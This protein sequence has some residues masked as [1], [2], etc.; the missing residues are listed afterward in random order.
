M[1][2]K[3]KLMPDY[4]CWPLWNIEEPDNINPAELPLSAKT[5]EGLLKWAQTFDE[6]LNWDDPASSG[7]ESEEADTAFERE[8][9]RL[10]HQLR[11][12][13]AP[14]YEVYYFSEKLHRLVSH[15]TH[16]PQVGI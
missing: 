7:F 8:G 3:I 15:P 9:I 16:I 10:W 14:N 13:L 6:T 11:K 4:Q 5:I 1:A 2:K 12:E